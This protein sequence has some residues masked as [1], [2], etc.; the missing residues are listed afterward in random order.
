M[1]ITNLAGTGWQFNETVDMAGFM[2]LE[3]QL[4]RVMGRA[5]GD[6]LVI[7]MSRLLI[8]QIYGVNILVTAHPS[9][10]GDWIYG[11]IPQNGLGYSEGWYHVNVNTNAVEPSDVPRI[12]ITDGDDVE[13]AAF[14]AWLGDNAELIYEPSTR[15]AITA[16]EL[17]DIGDAI[18]SKNYDYAAYSPAEMPD[19]IRGISDVTLTEK[20]VTENGVYDAGDDNADGYSSVTVALDIQTFYTGTSDPPPRSFGKE[21]DL[22]LVI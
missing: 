17:N 20:T 1:A 8:Y 21:G 3:D 7:R 10:D 18:R 9:S 11:Y 14:I 22:Y 15:Y 4:A 5:A 2:Q 12:Y 16:R 19:A 13:Y 6:D